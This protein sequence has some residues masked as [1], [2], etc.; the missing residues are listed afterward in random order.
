VVVMVL[1]AGLVASQSRGGV[2][3]FALTLLVLPLVSR[4]RRRT[5]FVAVFLAGLG[6]AW[7]G[8]GGILSAFEARGIKGS[9]LDLWTDM[10]PMFPRFPV[11][12][13]GLNAFSTAYPWYQT[14]WPT[15]WIGEAHNEYLQ[16]LLDA[17]LVGFVILVAFLVLVFKAAA[18]R[19]GTAPLEL[20]IFGALLTLAF[21]NLVDFN[22]QIPANAATWTALAALA[23]GGPGRESNDAKP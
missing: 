11:F 12:G 14:V 4:R 15:E 16:V 1:V 7:I 22:W 6:V 23:T 17:G 21:H 13:L 9:R 8:L 10:I 3:A 5:A 20:G 19:A 2:S 18:R